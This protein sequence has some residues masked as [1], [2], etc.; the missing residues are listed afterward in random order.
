[1]GENEILSLYDVLTEEGY[2]LGSIDKFKNAMAD[3]N[4][5]GQLYDVFTQDGLNMGER[6][7]FFFERTVAK[8]PQEAEAIQSPVSNFDWSRG[9]DSFKEP[10]LST[11]FSTSLSKNSAPP[12]EEAKKLRDLQNKASGL[13][14]E[15]WRNQVP[16]FA[17]LLTPKEIGENPQI[18]EFVLK[19]FENTPRELQN[20]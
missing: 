15:E 6:D 4:K 19:N 1:M 3:R 2:N 9:G 5:S 13:T 10:L 14:R 16:L 11:S 8:T 12:T 17:H 20:S 7:K 18:D